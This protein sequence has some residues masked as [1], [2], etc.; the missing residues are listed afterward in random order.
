MGKKKVVVDTNNLIAALGWDG[1]PRA[2]FRK[3]I[4]RE[5]K[6]FISLDLLSELERVMDYPKFKFSEAQKKLFLEI[7]FDVANVI[8]TKSKFEIIKDDPDDNMLLE[9]ALD[10][11]A[12][13]I[14]SGDKHLLKLKEF[15]DIKII[16]AKNFLKLLN[17]E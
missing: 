6:W 1:N 11:K 13:F 9:C 5:V 10:S 12:D 15:K 3:I 7:I 8:S 14:I 16:K 2:L 4:D 17:G